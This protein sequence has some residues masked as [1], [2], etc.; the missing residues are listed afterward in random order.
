MRISVV[1]MRWRMDHPPARKT[2][3]APET[4]VRFRTTAPADPPPPILHSC[5]L[6]GKAKC[7]ERRRWWVRGHAQGELL[8][9]TTPGMDG[10]R[11]ECR[12]FVMRTKHWKPRGM[13]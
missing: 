5:A 6:D 7:G 12:S 9:D 8:L 3:D 10:L 2:Y 4:Q 1:P 13:H 11:T